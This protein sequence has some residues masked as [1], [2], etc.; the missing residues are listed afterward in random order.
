LNKF[1]CKPDFI[2]RYYLF[3]KKDMLH[4]EKK[5]HYIILM[6]KETKEVFRNWRM[7]SRT[8]YFLEDFVEECNNPFRIYWLRY[9]D[10]KKAGF[11]YH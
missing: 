6:F 9:R 7:Q 10:S 4:H 8:K 5:D 3:S 2:G 1:K 11:W